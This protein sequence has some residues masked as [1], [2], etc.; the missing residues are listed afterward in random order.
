[1]SMARGSGIDEIL[2]GDHTRQEMAKPV[3]VFTTAYEGQTW[4]H[5][6]IQDW[7]DEQVNFDD[8]EKCYEIMES[9]L[10]NGSTTWVEVEYVL[11]DKQEFQ[12]QFDIIPEPD[13]YY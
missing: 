9:L 4:E 10:R 7:W 1:M 6:S 12:K 3:V 11:F 13:F 2:Y 5:T 8:P